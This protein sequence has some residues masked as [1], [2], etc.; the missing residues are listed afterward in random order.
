MKYIA[1]LSLL[2]AGAATAACRV[3]DVQPYQ[4]VYDTAHEVQQTFVAVSDSLVAVCL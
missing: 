4:N 3:Y 1:M 2:L